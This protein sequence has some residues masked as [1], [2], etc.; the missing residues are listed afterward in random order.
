MKPGERRSDA[1]TQFRALVSR[2][3]DEARKTILRAYRS[4]GACLRDAAEELGITER[5]LHRWVQELKMRSELETLRNQA[6]DEGWHH[7]RVGGWKRG[8]KRGTRKSK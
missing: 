1:C 5:T 7:G 4:Q 6:L 8:V 3:P 2:D